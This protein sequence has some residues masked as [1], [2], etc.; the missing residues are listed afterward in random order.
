MTM[1]EKLEVGLFGAILTMG[2]PALMIGA[3]I[4]A[5]WAAS[6]AQA[7]S[8]H[9]NRR[10]WCKTNTHPRVRASNAARPA[11]TTHSTTHS[12]RVTRRRSPCRAEPIGPA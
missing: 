12:Q 1:T 10:Y 7:A 4:L 2:L 3:Q 8:V 11:S 5:G 9:K 6:S